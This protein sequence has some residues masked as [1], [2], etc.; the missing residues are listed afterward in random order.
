MKKIFNG[1]FILAMV[2]ICAMFTSCDKDV[3][4]SIALSG[5]WTGD[6]GMFY[7]YEYT[8]PLIGISRTYTFHSYDTDIEFIPDYDYA[9]HGYGYQVDFYREGPYKKISFRFSWSIDNGVIRMYYPGYPEYNGE[10]RDYRLNNSHFTGRF[11]NASAPFDLIK[12]TDYYYWDEYYAWEYHY[13]WYDEWDWNGYAKTR[14]I[15]EDAVPEKYNSE[16]GRI[17]KIGNRFNE[18]D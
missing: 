4:R 9:T 8:N 15:S 5:Q 2:A 12:I 10:I 7:N 6:F 14:G 11:T 18:K 3:D 13:W 1:L 16:N 17:V